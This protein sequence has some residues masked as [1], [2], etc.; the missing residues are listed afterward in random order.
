[1][2]IKTNNQW[3][4]TIGWCDLSA[5]EQAEFDYE[6]ADEGSYFRYKGEVY[7]MSDFIR[8]DVPNWHGVHGTSYFS[9]ICIRLSDCGEAVVVGTYYS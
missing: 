1:M 2:T 8:W 4:P 9:G 5:K 3:R 7:A 6:G